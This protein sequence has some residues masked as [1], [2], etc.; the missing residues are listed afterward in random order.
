MDF[1]Q[2]FLNALQTNTSLTKTFSIQSYLPKSISAPK[3]IVENLPYVQA[4]G[5]IV[6]TYP[7][8]YDI[9]NLNCYC[10]LYTESGV[11]ALTFDVRSYVLA[12]DTL[13]F[14]D[15]REKHRIEIKQSPW[16][17]KVFFIEGNPVPF[18]H[19]TLVDNYEN[20][21]TF[22]SG[23]GIPNM[24]QKFYTQLDKNSEKTFLQAKFIIDILLEV[25]LEKNRLEESDT[26]IAD[27]L[28]E[29]KHNFDSNYQNSFSL[30]ALE[31]EYHISKYRICREFTE[32]FDA[33]PI[34]YLNHKRIE[35]AKEVLINTDKRINEIGRMVGF[36]NT[37]H[38][39][40]LFK[41]QTG[42]T[43]LVFRKQPPALT[44]FN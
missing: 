39:I 24:L 41:Q 37:N 32:Y 7:Y 12:P 36:E 29:I 3:V 33:S 15:C 17:Y 31:K 26:H 20:L 9:S 25:I 18:L 35:V 10:L 11:G 1:H 13:A 6:S 30:D 21:H 8:Y 14:I 40:R 44:F 22:L 38:F 4:Y 2:S 43:P 42:V 27:Y 16:N 5:N 23:S 34:H 28:V 19:H